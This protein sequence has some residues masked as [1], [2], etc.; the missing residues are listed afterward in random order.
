MKS[1]TWVREFRLASCD[2]DSE[3]NPWWL[4]Q[5]WLTF[6]AFYTVPS[7]WTEPQLTAPL[8]WGPHGDLSVF[9]NM[10]NLHSSACPWG[11]HSISPGHSPK[12]GGRARE[13]TCSALL[14]KAKLFSTG[15]VYNGLF[16][17]LSSL[18]QVR[19][20]L[21]LLITSKALNQQKGKLF[22]F[23]ASPPQINSTPK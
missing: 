5:L 20:I 18:S 23:A 9:A 16:S 15:V 8:C 21:V 10:N 19:G 2:A 6:I 12:R 13:C 4:V 7:A 11:T 17:R 3:T 1:E 14:S 22:L